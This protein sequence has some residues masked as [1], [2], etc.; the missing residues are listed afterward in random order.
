MENKPTQDELIQKLKEQLKEVETTL[1]LINQENWITRARRAE[2]R[3]NEE[4]DFNKDLARDNSDLR[5]ENE[6]LSMYVET[7]EQYLDIYP[8]Q[9]D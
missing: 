5:R 8:T 1:T 3:L 6:R 2:R 4:R 7:F 9:F